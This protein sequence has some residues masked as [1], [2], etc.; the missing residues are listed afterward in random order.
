MIKKSN[1][2]SIPEALKQANLSKGTKKKVDG[3]ET[4][5]G[6]NHLRREILIGNFCEVK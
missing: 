6:P 3:K 4:L 2:L 1:Q 5:R